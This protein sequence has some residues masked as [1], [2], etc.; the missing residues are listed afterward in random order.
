MNGNKGS[1][2]AILGFFIAAGAVGTLDADP[3]ASV[4]VA[5]A[6][7]LVGVA[8]MASGVKALTQK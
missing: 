7:G 8:I 2:R 1:I 3:Q 6:V 4:L 5:L